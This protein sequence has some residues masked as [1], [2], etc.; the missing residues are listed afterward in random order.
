VIP[1]VTFAYA[2]RGIPLTAVGFMQFITPTCLFVIGWAQGEPLNGA[3]LA[4]FAFIWAGVAVFAW[5]AIR[6]NR[7]PARGKISP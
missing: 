3:R 7:R 2:A 4:S 6:D 5:G 1:L